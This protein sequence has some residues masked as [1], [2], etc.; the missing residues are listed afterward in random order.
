MFKT[1]GKFL[2][3]FPKVFAI[4]CTIGVLRESLRNP[5]F[6]RHGQTAQ[7]G[8]RKRASADIWETKHTVPSF[9]DKMDILRVF[10]PVCKIGQS[11]SLLGAKMRWNQIIG[12]QRRP[13]PGPTVYLRRRFLQSSFAIN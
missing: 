11:R 4:F 1:F 2:K 9:V 12:A 13:D 7:A 6:A 8:R 5:G 10:L 3:G